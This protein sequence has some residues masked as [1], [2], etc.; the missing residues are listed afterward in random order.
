[1]PLNKKPP[2][3]T[4]AQR[5]E[6]PPKFTTFYDYFSPALLPLS[7]AP[8][9][10]LYAEK[11]GAVITESSPTRFV[12]EKAHRAY[13]PHSDCRRVSNPTGSPVQHASL[14]FHYFNFLPPIAGFYRQLKTGENRR[15]A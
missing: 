14:I 12:F 7:D 15:S 10:I 4:H 8:T 13:F 1:M 6:L 5:W 2:I 3:K 11:E 9:L